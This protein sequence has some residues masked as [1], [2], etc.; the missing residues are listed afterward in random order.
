MDTAHPVNTKAAAF[1]K[2][3][4]AYVIGTASAGK[5]TSSFDPSAQVI[6]YRT[7]RLSLD[8]TLN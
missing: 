3:L 7:D 2:V 8:F 4:G 5:T 6:D 1:A